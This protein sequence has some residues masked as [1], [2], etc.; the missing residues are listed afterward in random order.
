VQQKELHGDHTKTRKT[1]LLKFKFLKK[2]KTNKN[3]SSK[4]FGNCHDCGKLDHW[5]NNWPEPKKLLKNV[6]K[7]LKSRNKM[8]INSLVKGK[9]E[10]FEYD[11]ATNAVEE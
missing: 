9:E 6:G 3:K 10:A 8:P 2:K 1:L 11:Q 7:S 5:A 4:C